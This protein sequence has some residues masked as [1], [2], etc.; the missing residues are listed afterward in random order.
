MGRRGRGRGKVSDSLEA[1]VLRMVLIIL[2]VDGDEI[3]VGVKSKIEE[4]EIEDGI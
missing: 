3:R 2:G 1:R 4:E